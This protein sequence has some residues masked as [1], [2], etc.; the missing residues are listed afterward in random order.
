MSL[1]LSSWSEKYAVDASEDDQQESPPYRCMQLGLD[2]IWGMRPFRQSTNENQ[3]SVDQ[4][5]QAHKEPNRDD[6]VFFVHQ[7]SPEND[8]QNDK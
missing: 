5:K 6:V 3:N 7:L 4:E 1:R 2:C 8:L